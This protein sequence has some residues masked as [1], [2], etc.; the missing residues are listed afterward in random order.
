MGDNSR[1]PLRKNQTLKNNGYSTF[2]DQHTFEMLPGYEKHAPAYDPN[3]EKKPPHK[4]KSGA[5]YI[6]EWIGKE[7]DGYGIQ[8]WPDGARYDGTPISKIFKNSPSIFQ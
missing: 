6:G 4:F 3:R 1:G 2:E 8:K 5:V 7:R